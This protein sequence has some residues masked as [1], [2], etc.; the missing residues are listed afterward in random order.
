M[1]KLSVLAAVPLAAA[2]LVPMPGAL[3]AVELPSDCAVPPFIDLSKYNVIIGTDSS[4][5]LKGT[6][7][8][9]FICGLLG[10]TL[11]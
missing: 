8:Q 1:R 4:E 2:L 6:D 11:F 3:A 10:T 9:D 5:V 7:G